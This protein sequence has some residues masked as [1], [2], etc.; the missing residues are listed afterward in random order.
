MGCFNCVVL[1]PEVKNELKDVAPKLAE[2][3]NTFLIKAKTIEKEQKEIIEERHKKVS[4]ADKSDDNSLKKLLLEYNKKEIENEKEII[5]NQVDKLHTIYETS[6]EIADK[7]KKKLLDE[8]KKQAEKANE[9]TKV[10]INAS[11]KELEKQTP[12]DFLDSKYGKPLKKAIE[13]EGLKE[14]YLQEFIENL[15]KER[16]KRREDE[17]KEFGISQ[18]EFPP[19]DELHFTTKELYEAIFEEYKDEFKSQIMEKILGKIK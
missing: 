13:K 8:F 1:P 18:N 5:G 19:E 12:K 7:L 16:K 15:K 4:E 2:I 10:G 3:S 6:L 11:I 14:E 9:I 17:R